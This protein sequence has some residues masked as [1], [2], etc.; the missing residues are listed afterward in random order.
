MLKITTVKTNRRCRIVLEGGL[1][2]PWAAELRKEWSYAR[3]STGDLSLIVDVRNVIAID[4][5][6]K[7]ILLE[8]MSAG[9]KVICGGVFNR[10]VIQHLVRSVA[11]RFPGNPPS[12]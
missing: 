9:T 3:A 12:A 10:Y 11:S 6:G 4:Q 2:S 5:E 1:V 8:M 7:D